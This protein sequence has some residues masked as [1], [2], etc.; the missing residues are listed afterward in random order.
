[1]KDIFLNVV[2]VMC[3]I[4]GFVRCLDFIFE[5]AKTISTWFVGRVAVG[6]L[7]DKLIELGVQVPE[8]RQKDGHLVGAIEFEGVRKSFAIKLQIGGASKDAIAGLANALIAQA[9]FPMVAA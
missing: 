6:R 7:R 8:L 4:G 9:G 1:M 5:S 3:L 2:L